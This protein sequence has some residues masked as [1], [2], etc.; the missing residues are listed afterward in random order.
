MREIQRATP[1]VIGL[2]AVGLLALGC[3]NGAPEE[4]SAGAPQSLGE[5]GLT[6]QDMSSDEARRPQQSGMPAADVK[7]TT[8]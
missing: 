8:D 4:E 6:P 2:T 7:R 1:L 3:G 5:G